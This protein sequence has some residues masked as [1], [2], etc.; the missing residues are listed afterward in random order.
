MGFFVF[1]CDVLFVFEGLAFDVVLSQM[2]AFATL[3]LLDDS[4]L[5]GHQVKGFLII[6][7]LV[8]LLRD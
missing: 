8:Y 2:L 1:Y 5:L 3:S 4:W 7:H 6:E